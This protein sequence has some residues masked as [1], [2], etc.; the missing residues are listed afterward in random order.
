MGMTDR[1]FDA[2]ISAELQNLMEIQKRL[3]KQGVA[4]EGLDATIKRYQDLLKR[5]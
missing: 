2:Y 3:S 4:D 5:P 1:Q